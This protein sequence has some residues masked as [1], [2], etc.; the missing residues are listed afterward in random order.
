MGKFLAFLIVMVAAIAGFFLFKTQ[1]NNFNRPVAAVEGIA[2]K[3]KVD[4]APNTWFPKMSYPTADINV[5]DLAVSA[6]SAILV[7]YDTGRVIYAKNL[8]DRLPVAST[9]K[10]MTALVAME[11]ADLDDVFAVS[12][13]AADIGENSM[14]LEKGEQLKLRELLYGLILVSGNDAAVAITEGVTGSEEAFVNMMN[15]KSKFLG[16]KDS[17]FIN[18]SGLD[19]D[20]K[21][22]YSS[23]YD[24]ATIARYLWENYPQ[25]RK[26]SETEHI[27]IDA[28]DTHKSF[29]LYNDTNLLTSY[30]GVKGI[31]PGFTWEAGLCLVTYAENNG[32]RLLAVILGS[33]DR[34]GEMKELLDYGFSKYGIKVNHPGLDLQ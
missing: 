32:R 1:E 4:A 8:K 15:E 24:L 9:V 6:R 2:L 29:D 7:D 16:L 5:D 27:V 22:Q 26:I 30:P 31:K 23:A 14:S 28:T 33:D 34:R 19:E 17:L 18:A 25:F 13:K 21:L 20:G 10:I 3:K 12:Q 11:N